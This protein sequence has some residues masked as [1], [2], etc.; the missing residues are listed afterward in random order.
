M[1][2]ARGMTLLELMIALAV[3][4]LMLSMALMGIQ[5]PIDGQ[6]ESAATR[7]LWSSALR[8]RQRAIAT[9]QPVRIV[10]EPN[11]TMPDGMVRTVARWER[12]TCG[13]N[14]DNNT[15]PQIACVNAT[16]RTN[17]ACCSE[18]GPDVIIPDTMNAASVH[19]LCYLPGMGR[20][21]RPGNLGCMQGQLDNTAA[22]AAAAPGNL[23]LNFNAESGRPR[24]LLMVEPLTGLAS[25]LDCDSKQ[26][27]NLSVPACTAQPPPY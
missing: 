19:G 1:M 14:W 21:V 5:R 15:C 11:I 9:N 17:A 4:G 16:C 10:V 18:V 24:S 25:L 20:A 13:N 3:V 8:A 12:L 23:Q 7:E 2:R 27:E 22:L 26:A 6:R